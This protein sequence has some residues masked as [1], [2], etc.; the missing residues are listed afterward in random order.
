MAR[1][2]INLKTGEAEDA[3]SEIIIGI[4]LGT[5]NSIA[6]YTQDN[7]PIAIKDAS[8]KH[9]LVPSICLLY[10]SPSPRDATLSRMPSSA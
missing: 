7:I 1:I 10:T 8:G 6:A 5:T 4:D 3:P 2:P 9:T